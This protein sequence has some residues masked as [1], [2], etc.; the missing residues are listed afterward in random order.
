MKNAILPKTYIDVGDK[1]TFF[2]MGPIRGTYA[3]HDKGIEVLSSISPESYIVSPNR[4]I[5]SLHIDKVISG[6]EGKFQRQTHWERHYIEKSAKRGAIVVWLAKQT[7]PMYI[8]EKSGFQA[9]YAR[10]TR[11]ELGGWGWGQ[12]MH[13]KNF[14]VVVGAEEEFPGL[15]VIKANFLAVNPD[16]QFY[17]TLE[18]TCFRAVMAAELNNFN[19]RKKSKNIEKPKLSFMK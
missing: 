11:G 4:N 16:M 9:P 19:L 10:D 7:Q 18:E 2:L 13:D 6:K 3:W 17:S 1:L 15:S 14:P 12:L 8:D 5:S